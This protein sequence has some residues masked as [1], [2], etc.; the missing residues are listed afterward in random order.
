MH[1]SATI[2]EQVYQILKQKVC[3]QQYK[4][5]QWLQEKELASYLNVSRSPVREALRMLA[6]DGLV[7]EIPN[8]GIFVREFSRKDIMDIYDMRNMLES[9][10]IAHSNANLSESSREELLETVHNLEEAQKNNDLKQYVEFDTQLHLQ[11]I[12]LGGN[13]IINSTYERLRSM[14]Q[15]FRIYSLMKHERF[16]SSVREHADIVKWILMGEVEKAI[17][18]NINHLSRAQ[19]SILV[20]MSNEEKNG[21]QQAS[22]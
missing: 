5:G 15:P 6:N 11:I 14:L 16:D 22:V 2:K 7:V 8:K 12:K 17:E 19:E 9:Y 13:P 21:S 3:E 20:Y 10:A 4:P 18:L 1:I